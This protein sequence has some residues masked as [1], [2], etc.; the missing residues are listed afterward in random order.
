ML[1]LD[2]YCGSVAKLDSY[3][4]GTYATEK[5]GKNYKVKK[6]AEKI[7]SNFYCNTSWVDL[8]FSSNIHIIGLS[9]DYSETDLWWILNKRARLALNLPIKNEIHFH[10]TGEDTQKLELLKSFSVITHHH[11][12][13]N[14]DYISAYKHALRSIN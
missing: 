5:E 8:F 3:I 7:E 13:K 11:Q 1:G 12:I 9:L 4:K 10:S 14:N 6:M 2:H